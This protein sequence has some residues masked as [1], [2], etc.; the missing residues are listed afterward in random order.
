MFKKE[1]FKKEV[2]KKE[3]WEYHPV[4]VGFRVLHPVNVEVGTTPSK[5]FKK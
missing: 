2:F 3:E 4:K 5:V 1:V